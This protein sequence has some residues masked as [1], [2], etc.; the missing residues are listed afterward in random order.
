MSFTL[1]ITLAAT[2]NTHVCTRNTNRNG[3]HPSRP[4][5]ACR[6]TVGE[7]YSLGGAT[8]PQHVRADKLTSH[9]YHMSWALLNLYLIGIVAYLQYVA[10]CFILPVIMMRRE[11]AILTVTV[12][13]LFAFCLVSWGGVRLSPLGTSATI[14][15][16][17]PAL[18]D[19]KGVSVE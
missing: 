13:T 10:C 4:P 18:D 1:P 12:V 8:T 15:P 16:I 3:P 14:W 9:H 19:D 2:N 7:R 5:A 11:I 17:V 6:L